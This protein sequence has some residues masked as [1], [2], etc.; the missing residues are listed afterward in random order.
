MQNEEKYISFTKSVPVCRITHES[1]KVTEKCVSFMFKDFF[2]FLPS[3]IEKLTK[4][5]GNEDLS[6]FRKTYKGN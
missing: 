4:T 3:S 2:R 5:L 1:G 6:E